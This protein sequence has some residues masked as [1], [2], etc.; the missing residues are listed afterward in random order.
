MI[1]KIIHACWFGPAEMPREQ[2]EYLEG[3]R[4]LHPDWRIVVW[5]DE[6]A[7]PYLQG[8]AF[9]EACLARKKYAFLSDYFR[10]A[11]LYE[12]GGVYCDTDIEMFKPLDGF[13]GCKMF[14]G[15]ILD[16]SIGTALIGSEKGNPLLLEW[17]DILERD[18][19]EKGEFTV[20]NDWITGDLLARCPDFRL[21]GKRQSLACGIELY[22]KDWFERYQ[23]DKKSGGG[24]CEHH[25]FNSW[26]EN[27]RLPLWK[28]AAKKIL[29]R[30]LVS[31]MGHRA[32]VKKS[33]FYRVYLTQRKSRNRKN[34]EV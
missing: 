17:R 27:K 34:E 31:A 1:P 24:Y 16:S 28:R 10:L 11:V 32:A 3:W 6:T 20:S 19:G 22:P 30:K 9:V 13:L 15:F 33:R 18:F 8:S 7:A 26:V 25:C 12:F 14:L 2:K 5:T 21:N 23:V 29:P 4:R